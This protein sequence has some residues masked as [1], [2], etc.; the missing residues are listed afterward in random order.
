MRLLPYPGNARRVMEIE[1]GVIDDGNEF[2]VSH[3]ED[4]LYKAQVLTTM[5]REH[6]Q[7]VVRLGNKRREVIL[8]L[9]KKRVP[10]RVIAEACG[11]TDQALY[12]DLRK[13]KAG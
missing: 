9:R 13:H 12:A 11:I 10:Y 3:E 7:S 6:Q 8:R 2:L 5:M 1:M 4:D